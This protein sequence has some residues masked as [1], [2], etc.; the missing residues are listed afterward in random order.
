MIWRKR[1]GGGLEVLGILSERDSRDICFADLLEYSRDGE[2]GYE[3]EKQDTTLSNVIRGTDFSDVTL[4]N[5]DSLP[6]RYIENRKLES[7]QLKADDIIIETAGGTENQPTGRTAIIREALF[8][9]TSLPFVCASFSRF[10]RVKKNLCDPMYL[11]YYL[12]N[13]YKE[14][15]MSVFNV[16]HTG[17]S[18]FQYTD[19]A[20]STIIHLPSLFEQNTIA[21]FLSVLDEKIALN[22]HLNKTLEAVGQAVFRRWFVDF[23]FP[24]EEGKP[25]KS[26]GGE[27]VHNEELGKATPKGWK[28]VVITEVTEVIDCLH[29]KKPLRTETGPILLQVFN[30]GQD[31]NLDLSDHYNVSEED[32]KFW[33]RNIEVK[34][35][36]CVITNAGRVGAVA[37]I[38]EGF[39]FGIGRNMTA[40]R[41]IGI[42][43]TYLI[44]YLTS[45]YGINE[46]QNNVDTG[47]I[48]DSLNVKGIIKMRVLLPP[49]HIL[50]QY[51]NFARP[52]RKHI[53]ININQT[54]TLSEIRDG[55][56][57]KLMSGK[58]RV[59]VPKE[60]VEVQ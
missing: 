57:P 31:G 44:N 9:K 18:R 38:P 27:I 43:P 56:L 19:F 29:S 51:E 16:Q 4:L 13:M 11:Y 6:K 8:K 45:K 47:T 12:G 50:D 54:R 20:R 52:L 24:N 21:A 26:S 60:N 5:L 41:P 32:Y 39:H 42:P 22:H 36:D 23:E 59:P 2:W 30:I 49:R 15:Q 33:T 28:V 35:G 46:I 25:Y 14:G 17:V 10:L 1:F 48:L 58:I 34:D 55:L 7:K 40:I 37:Q 3:T 53:E